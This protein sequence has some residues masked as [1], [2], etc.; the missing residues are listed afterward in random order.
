MTNGIDAPQTFRN[1]LSSVLTDVQ[2]WVPVA[3]LVAGLL[4]LEWIR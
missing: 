3:V 1:R 2:F 4:L